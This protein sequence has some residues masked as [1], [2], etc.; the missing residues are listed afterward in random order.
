VAAWALISLLAIVAAGIR[1]R[2]ACWVRAGSPALDCAGRPAAGVCVGLVVLVA[3]AWGVFST[4][5]TLA[6]Q[7]PAEPNGAEGVTSGESA[8]DEYSR[9]VE[10]ECWVRM[11]PRDRSEGLRRL[12][13][14]LRELTGEDL[15]KRVVARI[16]ELKAAG[17]D[18]SKSKEI[19]KREANAALL[20]A[21]TVGEVS[22]NRD[23]PEE[24]VD[25][26]ANCLDVVKGTRYEDY[27]WRMIQ[28]EK[29]R[30]RS[31]EGAG[32]S[33]VPVEQDK[34]EV[35]GAATSGLGVRAG[36]GDFLYF[37]DH[38]VFLRSCMGLYYHFSE[39]ETGRL[40]GG[41]D[42]SPSQSAPS[43]N[44]Y[45]TVRLDYVK[46]TGGPFYVSAGGGLIYEELYGQNGLY[47]CVGAAA[48]NRLALG[49]K[50]VDIRL[51]LQIPL[52]EK[53]NAPWFMSLALGYD[54]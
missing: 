40:E 21:A 20:V 24:N 30:Q 53:L 9:W 26:L 4:A 25:L 49:S 37:T 31:G 22:R 2:G 44:Y 33:E 35:D 18:A 28:R 29:E 42:Y 43:E 12:R 47:G 48:G 51:G 16:D 17:R 23:R 6:G 27:I 11:H 13:A 52:G 15:K 38:P 45:W 41:I 5:S 46:Y 7:A 36:F 34:R 3:V 54:L 10:V 50:Q 39:K 14:L 19:Q 1:R 8:A 32:A